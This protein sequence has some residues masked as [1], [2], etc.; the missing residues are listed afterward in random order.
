[1]FFRG[2]CKGTSAVLSIFVLGDLR[3]WCVKG[4]TGLGACSIGGR[5]IWLV[6]RF[7]EVLYNH[8]KVGWAF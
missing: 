1:M 7:I 2:L 4:F 6:A 3:F 8:A 5:T